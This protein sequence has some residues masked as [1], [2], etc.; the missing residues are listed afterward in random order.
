MNGPTGIPSGQLDD[1][2]RLKVHTGIQVTIIGLF[3]PLFAKGQ[4]PPPVLSDR[5]TSYPST[6]KSPS[7]ATSPYVRAFHAPH[8]TSWMLIP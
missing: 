2:K 3:K 6:S 4:P 8:S 1:K 5:P 7:T